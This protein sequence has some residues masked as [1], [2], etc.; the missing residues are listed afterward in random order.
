MNHEIHK[1]RK[2]YSNL[3]IFALFFFSYF[4]FFLSLERCL[5]G[6]DVCCKKVRWMKKKVIEEAISCILVTMLFE[7]MIKKKISK[8]HIIHFIIVFLSFYSA[9]H[10]ID[11]D[12]HGYYNIKFFFIIVIFIL[13]LLSI[14]NYLLSIKNK[15]III[16]CF[17]SSLILLY[18]IKNIINYYS[19]CNG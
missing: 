17:F 18:A 15:K 14:I 4:S 10:G 13:F 7:L 5:E 2:K 8:L 6:E 19:D 16:I 12:D 9:S 3:L 11:F 1:S